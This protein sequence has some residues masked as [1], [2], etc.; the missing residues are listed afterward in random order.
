MS[1]KDATGRALCLSAYTGARNDWG[2]RPLEKRDTV[3]SDAHYTYNTYCSY[4]VHAEV[5]VARLN[6]TIPDP[7]YERLE[8]VR[9]RV[10]VSKVC[11]VALE[12][13]LDMIEARPSVADPKIV[14]LLE[15]LGGARE[16]WYEHG[17]EDGIEWATEKATRVE[18]L[19]VAEFKT[20]DVRYVREALSQQFRVD[21]DR[22]YLD[23]AIRVEFWVLRDLGLELNVN[24]VEGSDVHTRYMKAVTEADDAAYL[25]GW[26]DAVVEMWD[27][28]APALH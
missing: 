16:R 15:R 6:L 20:L 5:N 3:D 2:T 17:H 18:L 19:D 8:R 25:E 14:R 22:R 24:L 13:D 11:A 9:D 7:L 21:G 26:R 12:K 27:A 23:V 4:V 28:V 10:N 1:P